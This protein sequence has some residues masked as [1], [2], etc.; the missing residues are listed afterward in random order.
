MQF[1]PQIKFSYD[2]AIQISLGERKYSTHME[3]MNESIRNSIDN[4][5]SEIIIFISNEKITIDDNGTG[6]DENTFNN[7][8]FR[9]GKL[10]ID[11]SKGGLFGI[12]MLG[13]RAFIA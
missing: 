2:D 10:N 3:A 8:Y 7:D 4:K 13:H 12:G 11:P 6:M 5:S 9:I 1:K